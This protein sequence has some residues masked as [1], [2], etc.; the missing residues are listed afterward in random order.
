M[1]CLGP[2]GVGMKRREFITRLGDAAFTQE[3]HHAQSEGLR[4]VGKIAAIAE[5]TCDSCAA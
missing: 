2:L 1:P 3:L 4:S 5:T